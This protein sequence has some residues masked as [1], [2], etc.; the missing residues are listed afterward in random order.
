MKLLNPFGSLIGQQFHKGN[1]RKIYPYSSYFS[2]ALMA[3][4]ETLVEM[5]L[6]TQMKINP[7]SPTC[8]FFPKVFISVLDILGMHIGVPNLRPY[9]Y[10]VLIS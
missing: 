4:R 3:K 8:P 1:F 5:E 7:F 6:Y 10:I 9:D 2:P